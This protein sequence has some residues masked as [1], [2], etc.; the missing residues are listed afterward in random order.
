MR[1]RKKKTRNIFIGELQPPLPVLYQHLFCHL[2]IY[3]HHLQARLP[4]N[5]EKEKKTKKK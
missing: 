3:F 2:L 4:I 5:T 1:R